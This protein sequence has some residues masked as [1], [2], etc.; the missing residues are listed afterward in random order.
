M[1]KKD[2]FDKETEEKKLKNIFGDR[3]NTLLKEK[4]FTQEKYSKYSGISTGAI[5]QFARG[6]SLPKKS[7]LEVIAKSFGVSSDYL[8]GKSDVPTYS[9]DDINK[10]IGL[11]ENAIKE[12]YKLQH[13]IELIDNNDNIVDVDIT[14]EIEIS[15]VHSKKLELLSL[16]IENSGYLFFVLD[17]IEK[18]KEKMEEL[19]NTK[20]KIKIMDLNEEIEEIE[21]KIQKR[22]LKLI[23]EII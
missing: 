7:T 13:N 20:E 23:K 17:I 15:K 14:K 22:F 16:I 19:E 1:N 10:K 21:N 5:S 9:I 8:I 3:F 4:G 11:S 2:N 12:L 18:Y 6:N